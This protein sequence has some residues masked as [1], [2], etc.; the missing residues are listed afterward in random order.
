MPLAL[1]VLTL[2]YLL[3]KDLLTQ[4]S[5]TSKRTE[6]RYLCHLVMCSLIS[7]PL[8][9]TINPVLYDRLYHT[10]NLSSLP[11][12]E[13][14]FQ[15]VDVQVP[16][17]QSAKVYATPQKLQGEFPSASTTP[18][19]PSKPSGPQP[20]P[21]LQPVASPYAPV[22]T[23]PSQ[24]QHAGYYAPVVTGPQTIGYP[25]PALP[26]T[27]HPA[28]VTYPLGAPLGVASGIKPVAT[29]PLSNVPPPPSTT[30]SR[31]TDTLAAW[32]DP[33]MMKPK[34]VWPNR[35]PVSFELLIPPSSPDL[36][37]SWAH[38][39]TNHGSYHSSSDA[40]SAVIG[41]RRCTA[42][43]HTTTYPAVD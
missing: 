14:P 26:V 11:K 32:N 35:S 43:L 19:F 20:V 7:L 33:P 5:A 39:G 6:P 27:D 15:R 22:G 41:R 42:I 29:T 21:L 1:A 3:L 38:F 23:H 37:P 24:Q 25:R 2:T 16:R 4:Q 34:K 30:D 31:T 36:H 8:P 9:Q 18:M 40:Y 12:P 17:D 10:L 28:P 13:F